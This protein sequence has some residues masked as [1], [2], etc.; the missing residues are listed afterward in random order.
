MSAEQNYQGQKQRIAIARAMIK[1]P[2]LL[3]L[4][5]ASSAID[6]KTEDE[7]NKAIKDVLKHQVSFS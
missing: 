4:D 7:I 3:I 5:D 2:R 6:S 1:K